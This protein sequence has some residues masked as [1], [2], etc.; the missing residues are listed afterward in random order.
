MT[1]NFMPIEAISKKISEGELKLPLDNPVVADVLRRGDIQGLHKLLTDYGLSIGDFE[2][3]AANQHSK[4]VNQIVQAEPLYEGYAVTPPPQI[5]AFPQFDMS[6]TLSDKDK[7]IAAGMI[8]GKAAVGGKAA[9]KGAVG[10]K[11][12]KPDL[13][14]MQG[15]YDD[16]MDDL[17]NL[18]NIIM[19]AQFAQELQNKSA[20]L[21]DQLQKILAMAKSGQ[22]EDPAIIILALAKV[23]VE[24]YGLI[25]TQTG[26]KVLN[27]N[28]QMNGA[29]EMLKND[30]SMKQQYTA[31]QNIQTGTQTLSRLTNDM[32][33]VAQHI[34]SVIT[35]SKSSIDA[36]K[37]A[38][39]EI[40]RKLSA[41][42]G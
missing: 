15:H 18:N 16:A 31:K 26:K 37:S 28:E 35:F 33:Q 17:D 42:G 10:S 13:S 40:I 6:N 32:N 39:D 41:S 27:V 3:F 29:Y 24:K 2:Q 20:E 25:F 12:S 22:I 4:Y 8:F 7:E 1:G 21:E 38:K 19:E 5:E 9:A 30:P 14:E 36:M 11:A 23:Q 34:Q